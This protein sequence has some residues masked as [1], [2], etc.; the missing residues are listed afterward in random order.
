[1]INLPNLPDTV[2]I[3]NIPDLTKLY[4]EDIDD[5]QPIVMTNSSYTIKTDMNKMK[6][7]YEYNGENNGL[8]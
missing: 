7:T 2:L 8:R 3:P 1:M 6:V 5:I 4:I